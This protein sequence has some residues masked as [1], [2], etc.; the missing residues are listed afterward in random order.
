M[1]Y[2]IDILFPITVVMASNNA[3]IVKT[4]AGSAPVNDLEV[5][6]PASGGGSSSV[7]DAVPF[8]GLV[9]EDHLEAHLEESPQEV[10]VPPTQT[11]A[12]NQTT[13]PIV[14]RPL[15]ENGRPF[16]INVEYMESMDNGMYSYRSYE[17]N[18]ESGERSIMD[19]VSDMHSTW[20]RPLYQAYRRKGVREATFANWPAVIQ[21]PAQLADSGFC[22]TFLWDEVVCAFCLKYMKSWKETDCPYR[23]HLAESPNCPYINEKVKEHRVKQFIQTHFNSC[24]ERV[25]AEVQEEEIPLT[26]LCIVCMD[27]EKCMVYV[28]CGHFAVCMDCSISLQTTC[29]VCKESASP[30]RVFDA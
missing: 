9:A 23:R 7:V 27:A 8:S 18:F 30:L 11:L 3:S 19:A 6:A 28:P 5:L 29:P 16:G 25:V 26:K 24:E 13:I 17:F 14:T 22:Y 21:Q 1:G 2:R 4:P 12:I 10:R 20:Q 15:P